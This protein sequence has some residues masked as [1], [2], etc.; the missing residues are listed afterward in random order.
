MAEIHVVAL[1]GRGIHNLAPRDDPWLIALASVKARTGATVHVTRID[2][3][4]PSDVGSRASSVVV[5]TALNSPA[6]RREVAAGYAQ[7]LADYLAS[8]KPQPDVIL[9]RG[10]GELV[11]GTEWLGEENDRPTILANPAGVDVRV[12][13]GWPDNPRPGALL[14]GKDIRTALPAGGMPK[15]LWFACNCFG[16]WEP[17]FAKEILETGCKYYIGTRLAWRGSNPDGFGLGFFMAWARAM[18]QPTAIPATFR[19]VASRNTDGFL[20][21]YASAGSGK[22]KAYNL[23]LAV[24][25]G[26]RARESGGNWI[27]AELIPAAPPVA[28]GR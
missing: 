21:M 22:I 8:G 3:P 2:V 13:A 19:A 17:S 11:R 14:S 24:P 23:A 28:P 16:I 6:R 7:K 5:K 15:T 4:L 18:F 1:H 12:A 26:E 10:H 25:P 20:G 27:G 9:W